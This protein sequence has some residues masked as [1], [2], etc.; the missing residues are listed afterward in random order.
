MD[1]RL[2]GYGDEVNRSFCVLA[3][4]NA[5]ELT[6][7]GQLGDRLARELQEVIGPWRFGL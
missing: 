1:P 6:L 4:Q 3:E 7:E 2:R 5:D